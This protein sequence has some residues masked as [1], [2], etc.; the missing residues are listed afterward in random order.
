MHRIAEFGVAAH[1]DYKLQNK[2]MQSLPS[3]PPLQENTR[4]SIKVLAETVAV[5]V[6]MTETTKLSSSRITKK[7]RI[8]SYI[9]AL[10]TSREVIVQNNIFVFLSSTKSALDGRIV[11]IDPSAC[12]VAHVL[13]KYKDTIDEH[14]LNGIS[15]GRLKLFKNG[16]ST[17]L[18]AV[19]CNGDVL[20]LPS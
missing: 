19:V 8:A 17:S 11:S 9:E 1:W 13:Q 16:I 10:T 15:E 12:N 20:T 5:K 7:G 3:Q 14:I 18:D 2:V 4:N 6:N